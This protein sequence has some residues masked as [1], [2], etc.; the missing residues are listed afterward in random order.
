MHIRTDQMQKK[1]DEMQSWTDTSSNS[2]RGYRKGGMKES[3]DTGKELT[4]K[5]EA[6]K[7]E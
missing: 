5:K 3:R 7:E 4:G 6:G 2:E 1:Q